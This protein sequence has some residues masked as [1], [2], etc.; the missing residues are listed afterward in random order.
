[1]YETTVKTKL[2]DLTLEIV[3]IYNQRLKIERLFYDLET[4]AKHG[5]CLPPNMQGLT[6][7]QIVDLKLND[8]WQSKCVP[9][10]GYRDCK[11]AV[12]RRS[13]KAPLENMAEILDRTR[14][15]AKAQVSK[16]LIKADKCMKLADVQDAL[17]KMRGAVM[18]VYP[19]GLPPHDTVRLELDNNEDLSGT[20]A[21]SQVLGEIEVQLWW[22]GKELLRS[23]TLEDY[24]GKNE[25]T[26]IV[27]KLQ[28]KGQG[29]PSREPIVS[30][31]EQK[32]MMSYY[33][34]KQEDMKKL[35]NSEEDSY[36]NSPWADGSQLKRQF[37]GSGQV[38]W[39]P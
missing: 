7:E 28:K 10:G 37:Q 36:L 12:G 23:K 16:D 18:I 27:V 5:I 25:K 3:R 31:E 13:G 32:N 1:M 35:E 26:K 21:A 39:K 11:D 9:S 8:E 19:M 22:A 24:I 14:Q 17:D 6:D 15:E 29:A 30:E 33:Y 4:L 38:K 20:Q 34:R 2:E